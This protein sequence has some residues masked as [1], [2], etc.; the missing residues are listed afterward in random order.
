MIV[1]CQL[2]P[3]C[4]CRLRESSESSPFETELAS[5]P[6][7][8]PP[9]RV[10]AEPAEVETAPAESEE[11]EVDK[12]PMEPPNGGIIITK[13]VNSTNYRREYHVLKRIAEGP[14]AVEF[15][16]IAKLFLG[17]NAEQKQVLK[18]FL[19]NGGNLDAV[20]AHVTAETTH[21]HEVE[22]VRELL[23]ID[24]MRKAGCSEFPASSFSYLP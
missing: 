12:S 22:G 10:G 6:P 19:L 1:V 14:R 21:L 3:N 7:A 17:T 20:E 16:N 13:P 11:E 4:F 8:V 24:G 9:P 18:A 15:P 23:T 5:S 2:T